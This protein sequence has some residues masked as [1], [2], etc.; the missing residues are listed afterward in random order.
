MEELGSMAG[1]QKLLCPG[2]G[3]TKDL[4]YDKASAD[5]QMAIRC[6]SAGLEG[7]RGWISALI[8]PTEI[9]IEV[10]ECST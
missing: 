3:Q 1:E 2:R 7:R 6:V 8:P 9:E 4:A 5:Y 10:E